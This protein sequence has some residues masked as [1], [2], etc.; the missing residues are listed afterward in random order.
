MS[1]DRFRVV[2]LD[3]YERFC[4]SVPAYLEASALADIRVLDYKLTN[5]EV[6]SAA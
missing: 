2:V 6:W 5:D 1:E 4:T 3:D